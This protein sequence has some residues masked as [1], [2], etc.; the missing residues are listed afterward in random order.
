MALL[1]LASALLQTQAAPQTKQP[2]Q[3]EIEAFETA[4]LK[5]PPQKGGIVFVGSSSIRMWSSLAQDFPGRNVINRGFG[6][7]QIADSVRY[8]HRVVTK[9]EPK[10]VVFYAGTNDIADGKSAETV[11]K[12]Y[13]AFVKE[14]RTDLP[15]V[16]IAFISISPAPS[17]KS[18]WDEM[19]KANALI[20]DYSRHHRG[21]TYIDI[22]PLMLDHGNPRPELFRDDQLH[23]NRKGYE[24]WVKEVG[25]YLHKS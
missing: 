19:F 17:R 20:R 5:N 16:K 10:M 1:L 25:R 24:L 11:F 14:V 9:Y 8:A 2:F 23:M 13:Q 3:D 7:S 6:G 21:L 15:R 12:D 22:V 18:K 4:D